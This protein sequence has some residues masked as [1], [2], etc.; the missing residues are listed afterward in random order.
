[1]LTKGI[2]NF[3]LFRIHI[4]KNVN[5]HSENDLVESTKFCWAQPQN[6]LLLFTDNKIFGYSNKIFS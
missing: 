2:N 3:L 4:V 6:L 1:M 5:S